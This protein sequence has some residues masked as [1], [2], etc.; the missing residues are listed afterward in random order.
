MDGADLLR[1]AGCGL[2]GSVLVPQKMRVGPCSRARVDSLRA[3]DEEDTSDA[4][5]SLHEEAEAAAREALGKLR[6]APSRGR[7][8]GFFDA[9]AANVVS[10]AI[11]YWLARLGGII[12]GGPARNETAVRALLAIVAVVLFLIVTVMIFTVVS[13]GKSR[14]GEQVELAVGLIVILIVSLASLVLLSLGLAALLGF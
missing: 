5:P 12:P 1:A 9:I 4:S 8:I 10:A 11:I 14:I 7:I 2:V 13:H 6:R 3:V